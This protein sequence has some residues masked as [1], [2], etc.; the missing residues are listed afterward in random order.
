MIY[1]D[2]MGRAITLLEWGRMF[3]ATEQRIVRQERIGHGPG[4]K[5]V[6]TVWDGLCFRNQESDSPL[7]YETGLF[8]LTDMIMQFSKRYATREEALRGHI[9][10]ARAY[11]YNRRQRRRYDR[12]LGRGTDYV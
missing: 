1:F 7:I 8:T 6:S 12:R 9:A 10:I 5:W 2:Q 4:K 11:T 3:E